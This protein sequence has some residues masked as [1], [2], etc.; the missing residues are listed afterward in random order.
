[1]SDMN[2]QG[3][4][5]P[6]VDSSP[7]CTNGSSAGRRVVCRIVAGNPGSSGVRRLRRALP[8][9]VLLA[10][11]ALVVVFGAA[12]ALASQ[13]YW[14]V[15]SSGT[16]QDLHSVFFVDQSVGWAVG[17]GGVILATTT[18][19]ISWQAQTSGTTADLLSVAFADANHGWAV[20]TTSGS[21][22]VIIHTSDGGTTWMAQKSPSTTGLTSLT[23]VDRNTAWACGASAGIVQTSDGG[24][25]WTKQDSGLAASSSITLNSIK[26]VDKTY[27]FTGG[28]YNMQVTTDGGQTWLPGAS[29][30]TTSQSWG[31]YGVDSLSFTDKD[32]GWLIGNHSIIGT[33]PIQYVPFLLH[34]TNGARSWQAVTV[35]S[36][37]TPNAV[38]FVSHDEGWI[39][40]DTGLILHTSDGGVT[41][42]AQASGTVNGLN[43]ISL[44][45]PTHG[46]AVG[47]A[48]TIV[49]YRVGTSPP[50]NPG[51]SPIFA[52]VPATAP[53]FAAIQ[54]LGQAGVIDGYPVG[55]TKEFRP[56]NSVLRAQFPKMALG[57]L[58]V[59]VTDTDWTASHIPFTDLGPKVA[60]KLYPHDYVAV[61]YNIGMAQGTTTT[62]FDPFKNIKR[63]QLIS[64][65][66]RAGR[67]FN[68]SA[69]PDPPADWS[70][71]LTP[72]FYSD[73]N[74]GANLRIAEYNH[75]LDGLVGFGSTW[76]ANATATRGEAAQ[77]LWNLYNAVGT[78]PTPPGK[79][80]LFADDFSNTGSGW[81]MFGDQSSAV[82]YDTAQQNYVVT[83][84]QAPLGSWAARSANYTDFTAE[85]DGKIGN[86][87]GGLYGLVFRLTDNNN[88]YEFAVSS[89]GTCQLWKRV[90]GTRDALVTADASA[91]LNPTGYNHLRVTCQG[92]T[93]TLFVNG[94]QVGDP[95][96]DT[97]FSSGKIGLIGEALTSGG[98]QFRFDNFKLWSAP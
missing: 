22:P 60:G 12:P 25:T 28:T 81:P 15:L 7:R 9:F 32:N 56:G 50:P 53:Y 39:I 59:P 93:I 47:Q 45:D 70:G 63:I 78:L 17:N 48:G 40:G 66:V 23:V 62:T 35:G 26:F 38:F 91:A 72:A 43:A 58:Q 3:F 68:A 19:G 65:V 74:H 46:F 18:G 8:L 94:T 79:R 54:G 83:I 33:D 57:V 86:A 13:G 1:M 84:N 41:W 75:L 95:I 85:V 89:D 27:G 14:Q 34:T 30:N 49:K 6:P 51:G 21:G 44:T 69:L 37:G 77:I 88:Y 90:A 97:T 64:M 20:G 92:S 10:L 61:A 71:V 82:G 52:D 42:V 29:I 87:L 96:T 36:T 80:I 16:A 31:L 55:A 4:D 67:L 98:V 73:P 5:N 24:A 76:D 2:G 11:V